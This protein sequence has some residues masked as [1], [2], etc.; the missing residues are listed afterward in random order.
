MGSNDNS[1]FVGFDFFAKQVE[2]DPDNRTARNLGLTSGSTR[3]P[4]NTNI[5]DNVP[6]PVAHMG[7][8]NVRQGRVDEMQDRMAEGIEAYP[9]HSEQESAKYQDPGDLTPEEFQRVLQSQ[10]LDSEQ[11]AAYVAALRQQQ[12]DYVPLKKLSRAEAAANARAESGEGNEWSGLETEA[13]HF[14]NQG[15]SQS[16]GSVKDWGKKAGQGI[17][18]GFQGA[19][20]SLGQYGQDTGKRIK[21]GFQGVNQGIADTGQDIAQGMQGAKQ[22]LGQYGQDTGKRIKQG[23]VGKSHDEMMVFLDQSIGFMEKQINPKTV[24]N[25]LG[26]LEESWVN[27][28][29]YTEEPAGQDKDDLDDIESQAVPRNVLEQLPKTNS[30]AFN[31]PDTYE[32]E[33][34]LNQSQRNELASQRRSDKNLD[35]SENLS[36]D[37]FIK[38]LG[39]L[40]DGME[41]R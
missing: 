30:N 31:E 9:G 19:G 15:E 35:S 14:E 1:L 36:G 29:E 38:A 22:S 12:S 28:N 16:G 21:Q 24:E 6:D 20:Q 4:T 41:N 8:L 25:A 33:P 17:A 26:E 39:A 13:E 10:G 18:Q 2:V 7:E 3:T 23:F 34:E 32:Q 37:G 5:A 40:I 11:A 27:P